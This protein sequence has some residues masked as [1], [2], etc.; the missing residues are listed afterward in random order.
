[1]NLFRRI[2]E[3]YRALLLHLGVAVAV[4]ALVVLIGLAVVYP[5]WYLAMH[6]GQAYGIG[7]GGILLAGLAFLLIRR[8]RTELRASGS[9]ALFITRRA[10]PA[11]RSPLA[12]LSGLVSLVACFLLQSAWGVLAAI[13]GGLVLLFLLGAVFFAAR[14][15]S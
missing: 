15:D 8:I 1:M 4:V 9:F 12:V 6:H 13:A 5:L 3:G 11:L 2:F 10:M 7:V 14:R